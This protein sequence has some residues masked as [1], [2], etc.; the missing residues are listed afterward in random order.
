MRSQ[1]VHA[2]FLICTVSIKVLCLIALYKRHR[3]AELCFKG[4][5]RLRQ[6]FDITVLGVHS[7]GFPELCRGYDVIPYEYK[8]LPLG[9]KWNAGLREALRYDW[10]YL[11]TIGSDDLLSNELLRLYTWSEEAFGINRCGV[12]DLTT[13]RQ[14]IFENNYVIGAGRVIRRDVIER[15]G[16]Q[17]VVKYNEC[18][19]GPNGVTVPGKEITISRHF[20]DRVRGS[21]TLVREIR[22]EPRLWANDLNQSLDYSSDCLLNAN[23]VIQKIYLSD[24]ILAI[25]LKSDINIW[26]FDHFTQKEFTV[27]WLS[28]EEEDAIREFR[29]SNTD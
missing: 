28:K 8:N 5:N 23:G 25:D 4:L 10:D 6:E 27:D 19:S 20:W 17:V 9:E 22:G 2:H 11:L 15:M 1:W 14:A 18:Q 24:K 13:G 16:D 26:P 21:T 7:G 29:S 3:V 12:I